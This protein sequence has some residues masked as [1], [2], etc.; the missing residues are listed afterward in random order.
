MPISE[1]AGFVLIHAPAHHLQNCMVS[2]MHNVLTINDELAHESITSSVPP[3]LLLVLTMMLCSEAEKL[4]LPWLILQIKP[5][6]NQKSNLDLTSC[7]Y[8]TWVANL[9]DHQSTFRAASQHPHQRTTR[10]TEVVFYWIL[11]KKR[12]C[13]RLQSKVSTKRKERALKPH[14]KY[15]IITSLCMPRLHSTR[16]KKI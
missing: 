11:I 8:P 6:S 2:I 4:E 12:T 1:A 9:K 10:R 16:K 15:R 5:R 14:C 13:K 3:D 7:G